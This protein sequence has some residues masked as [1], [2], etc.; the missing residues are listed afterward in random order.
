MSCR[1][2]H[3]FTT[4]AGVFTCL[5]G[6]DGAAF[7]H[8]VGPLYDA[9]NAEADLRSICEVRLVALTRQAV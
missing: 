4:T 9:G 8:R 5:I 1:R 3:K 7:L 2:L 6:R